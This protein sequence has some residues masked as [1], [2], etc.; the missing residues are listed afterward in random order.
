MT[1]TAI[2]TVGGIAIVCQRG[3]KPARCS[4][5]DTSGRV[6]ARSTAS[7]PCKLIATKLCDW[8]TPNGS[9][10]SAKLCE[11]HAHAYQVE[12][13]PLAD[14]CSTHLATVRAG[15]PPLE[16]L[17]GGTFRAG[18]VHLAAAHCHH[19]MFFPADSK[20]VAIRLDLVTCSSCR[21]SPAAARYTAYLVEATRERALVF[22]DWIAEAGLG[23]TAPPSVS[24]IVDE[25]AALRSKSKGSVGERPIIDYRAMV[26]E[27]RT[28]RGPLVRV[29]EG[30]VFDDERRMVHEIQKM[31]GHFTPATQTAI[32]FGDAQ[33]QMALFGR[34]P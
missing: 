30:M 7:V 32:V 12:G 3:K 17:V 22:L 23:P 14:L 33:A 29:T 34:A 2:P 6:T 5:W 10:C 27:E 1:C 21:K 24:K 26:A 31:F 4:C 15:K 20:R 25:L 8:P 9:T 19:A 16:S 18:A 11:R 13:F 28:R